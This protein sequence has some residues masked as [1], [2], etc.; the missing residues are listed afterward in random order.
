MR[1]GAGDR[2][3]PRS[4][5][6]DCDAPAAPGRREWH[7]PRPSTSSGSERGRVIQLP[8]AAMAA[9]PR[10]TASP[11]LQRTGWQ[12]RTHISP[13]TEIRSQIASIAG[14]SSLSSGMPRSLR[15]GS[16]NGLGGPTWTDDQDNPPRSRAPWSSRARGPQ[17][18]QC[19]QLGVGP[20]DWM[21][22]LHGPTTPPTRSSGSQRGR[23]D[24]SSPRR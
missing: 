15:D 21:G 19:R 13:V 16:A 4:R 3:R 1:P 8:E 24:E 12:V 23:P 11:A 5:A 2:R 18:P 6:P 20:V 7:G 9:K 22:G 14:E 10:D 17:G